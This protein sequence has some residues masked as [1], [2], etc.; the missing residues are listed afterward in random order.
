[1]KQHLITAKTKPKIKP[2]KSPLT[3]MHGG[4]CLSQLPLPGNGHECHLWK[5]DWLLPL[6]S[7]SFRMDSPHP[8]F[9]TSLLP[10]DN[11]GQVDLS[12]GWV[13]LTSLVSS[14]IFHL[15]NEMRLM[16]HSQDS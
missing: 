3:A 10:D 4:P 9:F 6:L 1:M 13:P 12:P 7:T 2:V 8:C 16:H 5:P 11:L 14:G 15:Q